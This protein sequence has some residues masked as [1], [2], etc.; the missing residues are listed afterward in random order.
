VYITYLEVV[1]AQSEL[2]SM[3]D[4]SSVLLDARLVLAV[5]GLC[6]TASRATALY[7]GKTGVAVEHANSKQQ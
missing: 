6:K 3:S 7:S 4:E 5:Y 2:N 1:V